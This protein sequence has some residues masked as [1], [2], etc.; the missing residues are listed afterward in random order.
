MHYAMGTHM[1]YVY[2]CTERRPRRPAHTQQLCY[3]KGIASRTV[4]HCLMLLKLP[5]N[6]AINLWLKCDCASDLFRTWSKTYPV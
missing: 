5:S 1:P 6:I 3:M 2:E 4:F